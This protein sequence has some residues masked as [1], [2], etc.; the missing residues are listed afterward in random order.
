MACTLVA[1]ACV[2]AYSRSGHPASLAGGPSA[3]TSTDAP[4]HIPF[5]PA[6]TEDSAPA[7]QNTTV[8]TEPVKPSSLAF[9][10]VRVGRN[11]VDYV[12]ADVTIRH[13][14]TKSASP[15][16]RAGYKQVNIGND[17][18]VRYFPPKPTTV[19]QSR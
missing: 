15:R 6:K 7:V 14:V 11:E 5:A 12:A 19:S 4:Q 13:F 10:R 1:A 17:V 18:T 16:T 9:R 8:E 3:R 2:I